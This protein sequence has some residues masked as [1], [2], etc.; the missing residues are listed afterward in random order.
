MA[1]KTPD[2]YGTPGGA[3]LEPTD[4]FEFRDDSREGPTAA[5]APLDESDPAASPTQAQLAANPWPPPKITISADQEARFVLWLDE[6]LTDLQAM[7]ATKLAEWVELEA[8]YRARPQ[9]K[10]NFPFVGASNVV[11]P[12]IAMAVDPIHARLDTGIF[13]QDPTFRVKALKKSAIKYAPALETWINFYISSI[14]PLRQIASPRIL[15]CAKL[16]T[17]VFK[18]TYERLEC[19]E[20]GYGENL[21]EVKVKRTKFAGPMVTGISISDILFPP[22]YQFLQDCPIVAER[23]RTTYAKLR[24]LEVQGRYTDVDRLRGQSAVE[25]NVLELAREEAANHQTNHGTRAFEDIEVFEVW[26]DYDFDDSGYPDRIT[27]T[28]HPA[29]R[30]LLRLQYNPYFHQRKPYTVIPYTVTNDSL[31]GIGIG[32]MAKPFQ[33]ALTQWNQMASDNAYLANIRMFIAK[34]NSPGIEEVPRLYPGRV[35]F[36]DN[37]RDDFIPFQSAEIYPST[38]TERQNLFGMVE[39]RTGVSDYLTGRE[40]PVIGS[41]A[42]ATST[43]ALIQ[44]GTKRVEQV[45]ENLR[46][47]FGEILDNMLYIWAQY[48]LDGTD[49][50]VFGDDETGTLVTEFFSSFVRD[51]VIRGA[52]AIDLAATDA[53]T[54]R[55]M[56]QQMQLAIINVMMGFYEKMIEAGQLA[57]QAMGQAP[58]FAAFVGDV[59]GAARRLFKELL[60]R[61]DIRN[62]EEFLPDLEAYLEPALAQILGPAGG[63]AGPTGGTA[64]QPGMAPVAPLPPGGGPNGA[65]PPG[66]SQ[67]LGLPGALVPGPNLRP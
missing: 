16:G 25:R 47:G 1:R 36:V 4:E 67:P 35:F 17:M 9:A 2:D 29:T 56:M 58:Q 46:Y 5:S 27:A 43:V 30:T 12:V 15:E 34:T 6:A 37:P 18:T 42:T 24:E 32:E 38:L 65:T 49:W 22:A 19:I 8:A 50:I 59:T 31:Y 40:S 21:K 3:P 23:Q 20:R 39:K 33:D 64:P 60:S 7:Q 66:G 44:E 51:D 55:Q 54:N 41:R 14:L 13:K 45:L 28:Y 26:C 48:S 11:L 62:P 10:K 63:P 52:L 53:A 61:Y 57:V